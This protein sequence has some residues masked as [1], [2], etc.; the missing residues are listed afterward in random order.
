MNDEITKPT[1][2]IVM[3]A[4]NEK[5]VIE[6]SVRDF[7]DEIVKKI[8]N[9]ELIIV[10]DWSTDDTP[11]ILKNL[12]KEIPALKVIKTPHNAGHGA[13]LRLGFKHATCDYVFHTDSDYQHDPREFWKLYPY[14]DN[15]DIVAGF[16]T[17]RH[18][19]L[20]RKVISFSVRF[21]ARLM[22]NVSMKDLNCPF[23]IYR[24]RTLNSLL[25]VI[26]TNAFAPTI[27][28]CIAASFYGVRIKEIPVTHY[29]RASGKTSIKGF[30]TAKICFRCLKELIT[31][32]KNLL[33]SIDKKRT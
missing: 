15:F 16:R 10:D 26:D 8:D 27:Q 23:K 28:L 29:P 13:A 2:S 33:K 4:Y 11:I 1:F 12:M 32:R 20:Y 24:K 30:K 25:S 9:S 18:D 22:F 3:P 31:L 19:P 5:G 6:K 7:Y 14:I 21:I 17:P